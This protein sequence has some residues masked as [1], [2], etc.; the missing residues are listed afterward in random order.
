[1]AYTKVGP[2]TNGAAPP[3]DKT[4]LDGIENYLVGTPDGSGL[5]GG[6]VPVADGSGAWVYEKLPAS[7]IS[8]YPA[9]ST[10]ALLGDG[11]WAQLANAQIAAAA[12]IAVSKLADP[13]TGKVV[14]SSGGA[15][16]AVYPPG[17]EWDRASITSAVSVTATTEGAAN[18]VVTGNSTTYDGT[19]VKVEFTAPYGSSPGT[20]VNLYVILLRDSTVIGRL[21][22]NTNGGVLTSPIHLVAFDTP[23]AAA[24]TYKIQA[25]ILSAGTGVVG[26]GAGGAGNFL[27]AVLRVTKA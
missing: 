14:G 8:G 7:S 11:S 16:A 1:M 21:T 13:T 10:K 12:A 24:H 15:A 9:D 27:P 22:V 19:E 20:N 3:I 25:Y 26:A 4:F 18:A 23:S 17:R 2:F 5:T 6:F